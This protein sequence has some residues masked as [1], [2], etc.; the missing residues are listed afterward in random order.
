MS[1][2][3]STV[4]PPC[5]RGNRARAHQEPAIA[6][7]T[8]LVTLAAT[9]ALT[10]ALT[11][12]AS[13]TPTAAPAAATAAPAGTSAPAVTAPATTAPAA[14]AASPDAG[15]V[16]AALVKANP[17]ARQ[18]VAYTDATDPNH[19]LGRPGGYTSKVS[20]TD[21]RLTPASVQ[22]SS[23]G[24]VDLGGSVEVY[25][26]APEAHKRAQFIQSAIAAMGVLAHEYDY[27]SGAVVL[28]VA[29]NLT[30]AQAREYSDALAALT[31]QPATTS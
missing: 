9:A 10:A 26:S 25:P 13:T 24:A 17:N 18:G 27:V 12:C 14:A 8:T 5:R 11:G 28:R 15:A 3:A 19:L 21:R 29:A 7:T 1:V 30:P 6:A 4:A 31:G 2:P 23:P 16:V 22:D 20:F